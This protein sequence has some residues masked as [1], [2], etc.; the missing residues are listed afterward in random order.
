MHVNLYFI[1]SSWYEPVR[2]FRPV[3]TVTCLEL[4]MDNNLSGVR[5]HAPPA[6]TAILIAMLQSTIIVRDSLD[7]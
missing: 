6:L 5:R 7:D 3:Y 4:P 2:W 1:H